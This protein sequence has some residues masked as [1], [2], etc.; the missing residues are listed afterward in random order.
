LGRGGLAVEKGTLSPGEVAGEGDRSLPAKKKFAL[1]GQFR[2]A[3]LKIW[4]TIWLVS[5]GPTI[6][7]YVDS[8]PCSPVISACDANHGLI[9]RRTSSFLYRVTPVW[10]GSSPLSRSGAHIQQF[11]CFTLHSSL[12]NS[13][14][15]VDTVCLFTKM[16]CMILRPT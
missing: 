2:S 16:F 14:V 9:I 12:P 15:D 11:P 6:P 13:V 10:K 5:Q 1:N 7:N 8:F 3:F 4:G